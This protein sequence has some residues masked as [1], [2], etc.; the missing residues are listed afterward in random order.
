M[1]A[2]CDSRTP[3][4]K[5][6]GT[7]RSEAGFALPA[8]LA[9]MVIVLL[10]TAVG[11]VAV[12]RS[13]NETNRDR[14][15][16]T[17]FSAADA[18]IDILHWRMNKQLVASEITDL[19]GLSG[20]LLG[21]LGCADVD[22]LGLID[23]DLD[24]GGGSACTLAVMLDD[25]TPAQC[26]SDLNV[27]LLPDGIDLN[28][29]PVTPTGDPLIARDLICSATVRGASRRIYARLD[30]ALQTDSILASPTSLWERTAWT[31][32]AVDPAAPCP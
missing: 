2:C 26:E 9:I 11:A 10:V 12:V 23:L 3:A 6:V 19:G 15:S 30:L 24:A 28:D 27:A 13:F 17:A 16:T 20:E 32:C 4:A 31:E 1:R 14:S 7:G 21:T 8:T 25:G 18:A 22:A 5:A 29:L